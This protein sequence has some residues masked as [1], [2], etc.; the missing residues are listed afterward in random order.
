MSLDQ[1]D[2]AARQ[3]LSRSQ[4]SLLAVLALV[5]L[6]AAGICFDAALT[7]TQ[8]RQQNRKL[9]LARTDLSGAQPRLAIPEAQLNSANMAIA[10]LNTPWL[11]ILTGLYQSKP[12]AVAILEFDARPEQQAIRIV[13]QAQQAEA[14]FDFVDALQKNPLFR[15]VLP[16]AEERNEL[17]SDPLARVRLTFEVEWKK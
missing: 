3:G 17:A 11:E 10:A 4:R 12:E 9:S 1:I 5:L 13:A 6:L 7:L 16:L 14:L 2:F 8:L 15:T